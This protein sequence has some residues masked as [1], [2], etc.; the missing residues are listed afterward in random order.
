MVVN[1]YPL[2]SYYP[3]SKI[4]NGYQSKQRGGKENTQRKTT[5]EMKDYPNLCSV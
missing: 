4:T 5:K 3:D 1:G 2:M